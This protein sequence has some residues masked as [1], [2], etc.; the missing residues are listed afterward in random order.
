MSYLGKFKFIKTLSFSSS[1]LFV[2]LFLS[3]KLLKIEIENKL[4]LSV[5]KMFA[6]NC[7]PLSQTHQMHQYTSLLLGCPP[8]LSLESY[9]VLGSFLRV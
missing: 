3:T 2:C 1:F 4:F 5:G 8:V 9:G 6:E 7:L